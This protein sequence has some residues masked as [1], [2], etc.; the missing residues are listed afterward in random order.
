MKVAFLS[1]KNLVVLAIAALFAFNFIVV[2]LLL[3]NVPAFNDFIWSMGINIIEVKLISAAD[4]AGLAITGIFIFV[5]VF[6]IIFIYRLGK[7]NGRK[8]FSKKVIIPLVIYVVVWIGVVLL[9]N[10][11]LEYF[12]FSLFADLFLI[13]GV[14]L[15]IALL[16]SLVLAI[17]LGAIIVI[18]VNFVNMGRPYG[19]FEKELM[20]DFGDSDEDTNVSKSFGEVKEEVKVET[21]KVNESKP[22]GEE[23]E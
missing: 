17:P 18:I 6:A 1:R 19:F 15:V 7:I 11:L 2:G 9:I 20:P 12:D 14:S 22:E 13:E 21:P 4:Q 5:L 8:F 3:C 16:A 10:L 23:K